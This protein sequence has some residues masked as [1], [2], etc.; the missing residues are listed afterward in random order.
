MKSIKD[1][2]DE[3]VYNYQCKLNISNASQ[4]RLNGRLAFNIQNSIKDAL[5]FHSQFK[6]KVRLNGTYTLLSRV[7]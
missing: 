3:S 6:S 5:T 1:S 4:D 7:E 2:V